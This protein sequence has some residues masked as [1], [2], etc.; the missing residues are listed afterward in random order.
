MLCITTT[1]ASTHAKAFATTFTYRF[2]H[3]LCASDVLIF[4]F[5]LRGYG[6]NSLHNLCLH[7]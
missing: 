5:S 3:A 7:G 4:I 6:Q 2:C 1:F